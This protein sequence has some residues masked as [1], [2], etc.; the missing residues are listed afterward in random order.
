MQYQVEDLKVACDQILSTT[1]TVDSVVRLLYLAD[2][3]NASVLKD[4]CIDFMVENAYLVTHT[5]EWEKFSQTRP[6]LSVEVV[7]LM[8]TP[9]S[10]ETLKR[11]GYKTATELMTFKVD[12]TWK[13]AHFENLRK[14][15]TKRTELDSY[16]I[17]KSAQFTGTGHEHIQLQLQLSLKEIANGDVPVS[18]IQPSRVASS[19]TAQKTN[20]IT[21][22]LAIE[23]A[24]Y[25]KGTASIMGTL[26]L[27]DKFNK[28][29]RS[30]RKYS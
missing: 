29:W 12:H 24:A 14:G 10:V 2:M 25:N 9:K 28:K 20:G 4:S 5:P 21:I 16:S 17:M 26:S 1:L 13:I 3:H 19:H 18:L 27:I 6:K 22:A 11:N 23:M 15:V 8:T 30:E 7:R